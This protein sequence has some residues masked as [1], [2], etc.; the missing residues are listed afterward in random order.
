MSHNKLC[1][2]VAGV[3]KK[4]A[5][6]FS[7]SP[8]DIEVASLSGTIRQF[9][10]KY[11]DLKRDP[12]L[13]SLAKSRATP[14]EWNRVKEVVDKLV[15]HRSSSL[16]SA[17]SEPSSSASA[18]LAWGE[19]EWPPLPNLHDA[20]DSELSEE[21][22]AGRCGFG[23]LVVHESHPDIRLISVQSRP[24]LQS[25]LVLLPLPAAHH[26]ISKNAK[27]K[28]EKVELQGEAE[29]EPQK[30]AEQDPHKKAK[31]NK[32]KQGPRKCQASKEAP[33]KVSSKGKKNLY[34]RV[35]H[36]QLKEALGRGCEN[37]KAKGLAREAAKRAVRFS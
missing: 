7:Q 37:A 12:S 24:E 28:A 15:P 34:S 26:A 14:V 30:E 1:H 31:E 6:I 9:L 23:S 35:Y 11:R 10:S 19:E 20:F 32:G 25:A 27:G 13:L 21:E 4:E 8:T 33:Q 18:S 5:C 36:R 29:E 16:V 2:A 22:Q 3:H 17:S